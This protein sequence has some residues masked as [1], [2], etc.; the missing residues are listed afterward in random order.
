MIK[1]TIRRQG[2]A[3]IMTIPADV[4]RSLDVDVGSTLQLDV[5]NGAIRVRPIG[6]Q[7]R[8]TLAE[9]LRGPTPA[10]MSKLNSATE[11]ARDRSTIGREL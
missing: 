2:G 3:A 7:R 5:E 9:L 1:V 4:L 6:T 8:Y 11:W 10:F